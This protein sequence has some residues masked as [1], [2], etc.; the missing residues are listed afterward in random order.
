VNLD[1]ARRQV[2]FAGLVRAVTSG[3]PQCIPNATAGGRLCLV[4]LCYCLLPPAI[5]CN[6]LQLSATR[7][8][9]RHPRT[10]FVLL[11][12][13]LH[14]SCP[15]CRHARDNTTDER[16]AAMHAGTRATKLCSALGTYSRSAPFHIH[17]HIHFALCLPAC[18][19]DRPPSLSTAWHG[20][21]ATGLSVSS[22]VPSLQ[23]ICSDFFVAHPST[24]F[25][26][27]L[28]S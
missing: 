20:W 2:S 1:L 10:A 27:L 3:P 13:A 28:R 22:S 18:P 15:S 25:R 9:A 8:G 5:A 6:H 11:C 17:I 16:R 26:R 21:W 14:L 24:S 23:Q 19:P 12:D 4:L 7:P